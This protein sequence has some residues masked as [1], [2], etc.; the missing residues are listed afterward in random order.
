MR[1]L[2]TLGV[3]ALEGIALSRAKPLVLLL[4]SPVPV[5]LAPAPTDYTGSMTRSP[6]PPVLDVLKALANDV[7][8]ELVRILASGER[9]V[10]DLEAVLDLPQSKVSYHLA[11]LREVGLVTN[12]QRGKNSFY[13]LEREVLYGIASDLLRALLSPDVRLTQRIKSIC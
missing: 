10:C 12:E 9:C 7:R 1:S 4:T 2:T 3:L 5:R 8:F 6:T 13:R 11:A